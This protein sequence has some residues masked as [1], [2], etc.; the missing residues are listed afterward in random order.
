MKSSERK[1]WMDLLERERE[2]H[3]QE[4]ARLL[5]EHRAE[6]ATLLDRIQHPHVRQVEPVVMDDPEPPADAAEMAWVGQEVPEFI[7]VGSEEE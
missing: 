7:Q 6:T 4:L 2:A 3:R 5:A 1:D